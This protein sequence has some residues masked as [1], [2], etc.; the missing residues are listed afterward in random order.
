VTEG[1]LL[2][3]IA[4]LLRRDIGPAIDGEYPRT[5]AFMAAV[6]LQKLGRQ[7]ALSAEHAAAE[8]ADLAALLA[9]LR[10]RLAEGATPAA[11]RD[12]VEGLAET[13]NGP[14]LC[15]LIEALY[16]ARGEL[17]EARFAALLGRT[18]VT[19]RR[20]IDRRMAVAE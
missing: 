2:E 11:V 18:R 19:L 20:S 5:Q 1:E 7:L 16:T 4:Q 6:V 3:R 13:R 15:R 12:A 8:T 10:A 17:G 14:A 9:D